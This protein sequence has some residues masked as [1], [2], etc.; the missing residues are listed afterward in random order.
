MT[1][2]FADTVADGVSATRAA[3]P[4]WNGRRMLLANL[5]VLGVVV[6]FALLFRFAAALFILFVGVS[7][8]MAVK[9]GVEWLR[10]RGLPR[11]AGALAVYAALGG[12]WAGVL[13]LA[14]PVVAE[15]TATLVARAP[16][17]FERLRTELLSS[18]SHTLQRI[19]WYLP[20]AAE[21]SGTPAID[22]K[23]VLDTGGAVGRNLFTI[24]AVLLLGFYWTLEGERR[25]RALVLFAPF[26]RR[27]AIRAFITEIERT[28]GAYLRGQSL[29]CLVIGLLA[30][31]IYRL[32]GLPH[33][34]IVGVVYAIGEAIPVVGPII[35]TVVAAMVAGSVGPSLVLGVVVAAAF[36]Q[37][38]ENY[39]LIPRVMV[40][41]VGDE[42]AGDA[43]GDHRVRVRAGHR[44]RDPRHPTGGDRAASA[45]A[46]PAG[47]GRAARRAARRP[48]SPE[49]RPLRG[50]RADRRP[51]QA[52]AAGR[53]L[54]IDGAG[55][56]R[57]RGYRHG[58][59][60]LARQAGDPVMKRVALAAVISLATLTV[61]AVLWR[62]RDA[63]FLFALSVVVAAAA[64]PA[65]E[66]LERRLGRTLAVTVTYVMGLGLF[67]I[68][69]TS[70]RA[71][72]CASSTTPPIRLSAAYDRLRAP[73]ASARGLLASLLGRLPPVAALY[74]A[75]GGARPTLLL[76][77]ALGLTRNAI[78]VA[79]QIIVVV[80]LSAYW[81]ASREAFE[82]LWLSLVPAPQ[83]PRARDVWR[84]SNAPSDRTCAARSR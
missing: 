68:F 42:P 61:V 43:A 65:I 71:A 7:L 75:I 62:F 6:C 54:A 10:R 46:L 67:G 70:C 41:V 72:S 81:S 28:V 57:H 19:A 76:D 52:V 44:G 56:G 24:V 38:F 32:I 51:A 14:V 64:R 31:V 74:H 77:Q 79:A 66:V 3:F 35:G 82:R 21:R 63:A 40:R 39:V 11:W 27:R 4:G 48:R 83:R 45:V 2:V 50:G 69:A 16:H 18:E 53:A 12:M 60:S 17:H 29:V 59:R 36:L 13:T 9:P 47:R 73:A 78:D 5:V 58:P 34:G 55:R 26:D 37:L 15:Q 22:V 33:A 80:A 8:G 23:S 25:M 30:F 1:R 49:R 20:S 84:A